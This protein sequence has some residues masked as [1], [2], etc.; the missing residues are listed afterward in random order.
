MMKLLLCLFLVISPLVNASI[1]W[2]TIESNYD[3]QINFPLNIVILD[4]SKWTKTE[5][6]ERVRRTE[7]IYAT[8]DVSFSP[9]NIAV[10]HRPDLSSIDYN[11]KDDLNLLLELSLFM[12]PLIFF[13][14][15]N[16]ATF[17]YPA[18][19]WIDDSNVEDLRKRV[20][21][22]F[23]PW[24]RVEEID[25]A[26]FAGITTYEV[27]AHEL[28]HILLNHG[29]HLEEPENIMSKKTAPMGDQLN[30]EQ[31]ETLKARS[32]IFKAAL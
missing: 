31:C 23:H 4:Q 28:G 11:K 29:E 2:E 26:L 9:I 21:Y 18:W 14:N 3:F 30:Q 22:V 15:K 5:V 12:R 13:M 8:C 10:E 7:S 16:T 27:L 6:I 25:L 17:S 24:K 32:H 19:A 20:G 1:T